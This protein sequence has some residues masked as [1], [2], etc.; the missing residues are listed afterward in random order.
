MVAVPV[1]GTDAIPGG[2]TGSQRPQAEGEMGRH[3]VIVS[4]ISCRLAQFG[5]H[6]SATLETGSEHG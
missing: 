2:Q 4:G 6:P 5:L 1:W 3:P